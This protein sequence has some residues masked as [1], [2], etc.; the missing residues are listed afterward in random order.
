MD[1]TSID[2]GQSPQR[3]IGAVGKPLGIHNRADIAIAVKDDHSVGDGVG[4]VYD[5]IKLT[6]DPRRGPVQKRRTPPVVA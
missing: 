3:T 1:R 6:D 2:R 5:R 4:P